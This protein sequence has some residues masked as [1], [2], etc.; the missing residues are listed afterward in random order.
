MKIKY[1]SFLTAIILGFSFSAI[2][3]DTIKASL[4]EGPALETF[5][6][7]LFTDAS[8][9]K[10]YC[11]QKVINQT[12][13]RILSLGYE[14][15]LGFTNKATNGA[16]TT[17]TKVK[18][19]GGVRASATVL[20][21]STNKL[22]LSFGAQFWGSKFS[23]NAAAGTGDYLNNRNLQVAGVNA[24]MFKPLNKRNFILAQVN[25]DAST[26]GQQSG[27]YFDTDALTAYGTVLY[28]WKKDDYKMSGIGI[29][30][31][32]RLGRALFVPVFLYNKTFNAKWG[33]EIFL[34]A[35]AHVRYN[36]SNTNMLLA[37]FELEGQQYDIQN[38]GLVL[39]RGEIKPRLAY[40]K[41]LFGFIWLAAQAGY[42][43]N[44]RFNAADRKDLFTPLVTNNLSP[45]PYINLSL[46]FVTP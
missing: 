6:P 38:S 2:A 18:G 29:A 23:T 30:R 9:A 25:T 24:L 1:L 34:P 43:I 4:D 39:Q 16:N 31:T 3:Q 36:F 26:I 17:T 10:I 42:R 11:T 12:P 35:R 46:N 27:V 22:I 37:G 21:V 41:K 33:L 45:A 40:E 13:T 5:D 44:A 20:A 8:D 15:Q 7:S 32:L 14:H 28:G 19:F